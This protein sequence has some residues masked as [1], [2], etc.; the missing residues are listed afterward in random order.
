MSM[1]YSE[2]VYKQKWKSRIG[3]LKTEQGRN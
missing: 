1:V 2:L 3:K